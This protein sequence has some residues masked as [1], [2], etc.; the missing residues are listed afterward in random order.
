[1]NMSTKKILNANNIEKLSIESIN[2][3]GSTYDQNNFSHLKKKIFFKWFS[4]NVESTEK[5]LKRTKKLLKKIEIELTEK[6]KEIINNIEPREFTLRRSM[7]TIE[8]PYINLSVSD[9]WKL[10]KNVYFFYSSLRTYE[11]RKILFNLKHT[12]NIYL[13]SK[14]IVLYEKDKKKIID[15]I[16]YENIEKITLKD[17]AI[18]LSFLNEEDNLY[19]RYKDNELIYISLKRAIS[20]NKSNIKFIEEN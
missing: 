18:K 20:L 12:S 2:H 19:F 14:E 8:A 5:F 11:K 10:E 4:D 15:V 7:K 9:N 6:E 16:Y 17:H 3:I 13:S 1:M